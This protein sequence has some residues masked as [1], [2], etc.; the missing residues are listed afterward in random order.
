MVHGRGPFHIKHALDTVNESR[1]RAMALHGEL[2]WALG[3]FVFAF[4]CLIGGMRC[5]RS[6]ADRGD[7]GE[8]YYQRLVRMQ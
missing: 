4:C 5:L 3:A 2:V 8:Q 7:R 6:D 1:W